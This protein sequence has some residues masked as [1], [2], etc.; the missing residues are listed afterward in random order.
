MKL[1]KALDRIADETGYFLVAWRMKGKRIGDL[2]CFDSYA[3]A[4]NYIFRSVPCAKD[5]DYRFITSPR[6]V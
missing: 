4:E 5:C 3:E 1:T 2:K 6:G